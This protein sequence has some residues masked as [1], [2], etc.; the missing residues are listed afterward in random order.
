MLSEKIIQKSLEH[1]NSRYYYEV[2]EKLH[3]VNNKKSQINRRSDSYSCGYMDCQNEIQPPI[4]IAAVSGS[5]FPNP[6][7]KIPILISKW[8]EEN[9]KGWRA[10]IADNY[11]NY[12]T[13]KYK[14]I[15]FEDL[16]FHFRHNT[17]THESD[18]LLFCRRKDAVECARYVNK[19]YLAGKAKI[20]FF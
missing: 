20:W 1:A 14:D 6:F 11:E 3:T 13:A 7:K 4:N 12:K 17:P 19:Q 18:D 15:N 5:L 9:V 16:S 10:E 2:S 8:H